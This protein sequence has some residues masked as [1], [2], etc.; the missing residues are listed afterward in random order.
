MIDRE[1]GQIQGTTIQDTPLGTIR[2]WAGASGI[3]KVSFDD[4]GPQVTDTSNSADNKILREAIEQLER[5]F[6]GELRSF[7][8]PLDLT[9][10]TRFQLR[11]LEQLRTIPYG[12]LASYK[13]IAEGLGEP[14]ASRSVGQALK[15]NPIPVILPCHRVIRSDGTLGGYAGSSLKNIR[16]KTTL[17]EI[18]GAEI[19][20]K[21]PKD[22]IQNEMLSFPL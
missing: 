3:K 18:E 9:G 17:L 11:I 2:I 12:Q 7:N 22:T 19:P 4:H 14:Q 16:R 1:C 6:S 13:D 10:R 21:A 8:L 5:Y 20:G 15:A